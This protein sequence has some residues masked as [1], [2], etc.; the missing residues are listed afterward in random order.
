MFRTGDKVRLVNI[1]S[2]VTYGTSAGLILNKVYEVLRSYRDNY[3]SE[4]C[5]DILCS[6]GAWT[7]M[8]EAVELVKPIGKQGVFDFYEEGINETTEEEPEEELQPSKA[9]RDD[10]EEILALTQETRGE[11]QDM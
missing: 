5:V 7:V 8:K 10:I 4:A 11:V 9:V 1:N 3:S 6:C 2:V